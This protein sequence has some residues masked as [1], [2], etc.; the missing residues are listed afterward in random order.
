MSKEAD[1][2]FVGFLRLNSS[3]K[4]DVVQKINDYNK[5]DDKGKQELK[6]HLEK[7][8]TLGPLSQGGCPCCG[9]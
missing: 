7:G 8:M 2:V 4:S 5:K 9:K 6:E 1:K 3:D